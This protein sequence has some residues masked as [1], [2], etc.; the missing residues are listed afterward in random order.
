MVGRVEVELEVARR[1]KDAGALVCVSEAEPLDLP[2]W[3]HVEITGERRGQ[4][5]TFSKQQTE[6]LTMSEEPAWRPWTQGALALDFGADPG[7]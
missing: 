1:W 7:P 6:W 2:G 4:K 5:R 3:H